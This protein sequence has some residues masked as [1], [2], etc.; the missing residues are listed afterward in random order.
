MDSTYVRR[1]ELTTGKI[2]YTQPQRLLCPVLVTVMFC[3]VLWRSVKPCTSSMSIRGLSPG[4][5]F[6]P[7]FIHQLIIITGLN[8]LQFY[9][10]ALKM[11]LD[12]DRA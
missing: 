12:A 5:R 4:G 6:P 3:V 11:A 1:A 2:N 10:L 7:S 8:K 9:V